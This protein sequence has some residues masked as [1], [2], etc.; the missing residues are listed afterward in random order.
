MF[1]WQQDFNIMKKIIFFIVLIYFRVS[2]AQVVGT[3][4]MPSVIVPTGSVTY[5]FTGAI[6][7]W[8]VPSG[9]TSISVDVQGAQG[10]GGSTSSNNKGGRIQAKISVT[11]GTTL[12]VVVGGQ[13]T[14]NTAVYGDAGN[15]G[16]G[17]AYGKAGGGYAGI[18]TGSTPSQANALALAGGGGGFSGS[19]LDGGAAGGVSGSNGAQGGY[20][21]TSEGGKGGTPTAGGSSGG[22]YD[23]QSTLA[24]SGSALKGGNGGGVN[25]NG[26]NGG[27]G[28]G[29]GYFGGGGGAG[30]GAS[31]GAGGGGSSW[32]I[33]TATLVTNTA[34]FRVGSGQVTINW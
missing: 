25:I 23:Q 15:G 31:I 11:S 18:F 34:G 26:W 8:T 29:A 12:Y 30:G 3:P 28:G 20:S 10:G 5:T 6:Q 14:T 32:V 19:G 22:N 7:S 21:G 33:S 2:F 24:T 13:P 4:Y 27:G 16:A 1:I 9:V 17:N